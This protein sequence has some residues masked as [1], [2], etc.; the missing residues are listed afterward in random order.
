MSQAIGADHAPG[1]ELGLED[2]PVGFQADAMLLLPQRRISPEGMKPGLVTG[3]LVKTVLPNFHRTQVGMF[4][5][6]L[7]DPP[8]AFV[9]ID[10][11][12]K[13]LI[14]RRR[15]LYEP[16][17]DGLTHQSKRQRHLLQ[18]VEINKKRSGHVSRADQVP[19][20]LEHHLPR[21]NCVHEMAASVGDDNLGSV[22]ERESDIVGH[23]F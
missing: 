18:S 7:G 10:H 9:R 1:T 12:G 2:R 14:G 17:V 8:P 13:L 20:V 19:A 22:G 6:G 21:I 3:T 15:G 23:R 11:Q 4:M 5:V 16:S